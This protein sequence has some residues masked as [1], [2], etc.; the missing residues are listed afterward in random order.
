MSAKK[1]Q[2]SGIGGGGTKSMVVGSVRNWQRKF[3]KSQAD[4]DKAYG[5]GDLAM[6]KH[7]LDQFARKR[8]GVVQLKGNFESRIFLSPF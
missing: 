8:G 2:R 4:L 3:I 1:E 7:F 5:E 6:T